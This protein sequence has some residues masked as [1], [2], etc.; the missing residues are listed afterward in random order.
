MGLYKETNAFPLYLVSDVYCMY[1]T[2]ILYNVHI[3][4][5]L[6][7]SVQVSG[8]ARHDEKDHGIGATGIVLINEGPHQIHYPVVL[9][10]SP[11]ERER[12]EWSVCEMAG[13]S[14]SL[15]FPSILSVSVSLCFS[16][17]LSVSL[18]PSLSL[19]YYSP[20]SLL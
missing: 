2:C 5:Y 9:R 18:S 7:G 14:F 11:V 6:E 1:T 10:Q 16:I 15:S 4:V 12:E 20:A 19:P 13:C 3:H 17:C 8:V